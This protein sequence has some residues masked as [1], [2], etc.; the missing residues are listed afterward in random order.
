MIVEA[1]A[2]GGVLILQPKKYG[3]ARGFLSE[4]FKVSAL[5]EHGV[6]HEWRQDNHAFSLGAGVTRGLHFQYPPF[7]QAKLLRVVRGA[8]LDVAV[9]VR[10]GSPTYGMHVAVELSADNW[11][12][13]YV[14]VGMAHGYCTLTLETDVLY[15]TSMEYAPHAESGLLWSDPDLNIAWPVGPPAAV[16]NTR[17]QRWPR[18]RDFET[19]FDY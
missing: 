12:Q 19:P 5:A 8:I 13:L 10:R 4:T 6:T 9:D 17:D 14:P 3:D 11:R 1:T 2:I 18:L 16:L 7:A 15:K